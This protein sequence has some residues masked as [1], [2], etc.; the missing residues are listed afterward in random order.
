[1]ALLWTI[2]LDILNGDFNTTPLHLLETV[3]R[4][5][6]MARLIEDDKLVQVEVKVKFSL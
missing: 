2:I 1:L 5:V 4:A 6:A 3:W